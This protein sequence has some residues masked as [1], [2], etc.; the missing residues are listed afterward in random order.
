MPGLKQERE[1]GA[2]FEREWGRGMHFI[3][4]KRS[5]CQRFNRGELRQ[6][7]AVPAIGPGSLVQTPRAAKG[8]EPHAR[9][10]EV[11]RKISG[12]VSAPDRE[13]RTC[14]RVLRARTPSWAVL[15][16]SLICALTLTPAVS[17]AAEVTRTEY[18]NELEKICK[19]GSEATQRA[20]QGMR[21]DIRSERLRLAASKFAKA[22]RIFAGTVNSISTVPRPAADRATLSRWFAV[23]D[24]ET[25][26]LGRTAAALRAE[27]IPRFQRVSGR[28]FQEGSKANNVVVS[29]GFN[30]CNFKSSRYE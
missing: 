21:S 22:R 23:L 4:I 3:S 11:G 7:S 29:F 6:P 28:F 9:T 15:G 14:G 13:R 8:S 1:G 5:N 19:P 20:V 27:D 26:Y 18:V 10:R 16:A 30:Y 12:H 24:R 2:P 25:D 17:A